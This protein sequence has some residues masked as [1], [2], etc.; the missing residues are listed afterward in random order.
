VCVEIGKQKFRSIEHS[1]KNDASTQ[2]NVIETEKEGGHYEIIIN[3]WKK[4]TNTRR[5]NTRRGLQMFYVRKKQRNNRKTK[6]AFNAHD[7]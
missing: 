2:K 7:A 1:R 4:I 5:T 6:H 3:L